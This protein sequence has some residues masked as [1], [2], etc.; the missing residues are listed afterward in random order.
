M[1]A[2]QVS[3]MAAVAA[4][5]LPGCALQKSYGCS[6]SSRTQSG[7]QRGIT[8]AGHQDINARDLGQ[9]KNRSVVSRPMLFELILLD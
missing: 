5:K 9:P 2:S 4:A 1:H 3:R 6:T 8:A 7:A